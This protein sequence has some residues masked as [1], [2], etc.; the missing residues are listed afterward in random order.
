MK[1][2]T[3]SLI[4]LS[5][6]IILATAT[7]A[8][9]TLDDA[10]L[11]WTLDD[12][13]ISGSTI[14]DISGNGNNGSLNGATT[15]ADGHILEDVDLDGTNDWLNL[16][17][18]ARNALGG[19]NDWT[20]NFWMDGDTIYSGGE[21][22]AILE[23]WI[24]YS[25]VYIITTSSNELYGRV[26]DGAEWS[27]TTT[28][29]LTTNTE[30]MITFYREDDDICIAI[31][32]GTPVC[33]AMT[34]NANLRSATSLYMGRWNDPEGH[35]NGEYDEISIYTRALSSAERTAAFALTTNPY[36]APPSSNET[37]Y[38][39]TVTNTWTGAALNNATITINGE[40]S[41][42]NI[43]G[44]TIYTNITSNASNLYNINISSPN[45]FSQSFNNHNISDNNTLDLYE[46]I[47]NFTAYQL[48]SGNALNTVTF[49]VD[50]QTNGTFYLSTGQHNVTANKAGY[51]EK[52]TTITI[53]SLQNGTVN[54]T[55][56]YNQILNISLTAGFGAGITNITGNLSQ[57]T[58]SYNIN[59]SENL[60]PILRDLNYT[61]F[62]NPEGYNTHTA[63]ISTG[64]NSLYNL[65]ITL[66]A[67]NSVLVTFRDSLTETI[68]VNVSLDYF[69]GLD[70]GT[71][72]TTNGSIYLTLLNPVAY[73][74]RINASGYNYNLY[75]TTIT[76]DSYSTITI[77][78]NPIGN[79]S[80]ITV[81]IVDGGAAPVENAQ[82]KALKYYVT[83]NTYRI[84]A[85]G[86]TNPD[87]ETQLNLLTGSEFYKFVVVV[88]NQTVKT[89][90][91]FIITG[92]TIIIQV[93][94]GEDILTSFRTI[95]GMD[96]SLVFNKGTN[97]FRYD[98]T[99]NN[100]VNREVCLNTYRTGTLLDILIN[101]TCV[102]G[103]SATILH[104][105]TNTSGLSYYSVATTTID[106]ESFVLARES[107]NYPRF[108]IGNAGLLAQIFLT[109]I[110][111]L[112]GFLAIELL[113]ILAPLSIIIG[114]L[115]GLHALQLTVTVPLLI[116]GI[117]IMFML[118]RNA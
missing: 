68:I 4:F 20:L 57:D 24:D 23:G 83:D 114:G 101:T 103:T 40:G 31:D 51:Y 46:S 54:I 107:Y 13:N 84:V 100:N 1:F 14:I 58:Y 55:G 113:L 67:Y 80:L 11:Y 116:I 94:I 7:S 106:S 22:E 108:S 42:T 15:G 29:T 43:T 39:F 72:T 35:Y 82:V 88:D 37:N 25:A 50:G 109:L 70:S 85:S 17:T 28:D 117:I 5:L 66:Y 97:S 74:F 104:G 65:S 21:Y 110:V 3:V 76:D 32:A 95:Q 6:L 44:N 79:T 112:S 12:D 27:V 9:A 8:L 60:I 10:L 105:V 53:S 73:T 69:S 118:R 34:T 92:T 86:I 71:N 52:N 26:H 64:D 18:S 115:A 91:P 78:L 30:H 38:T 47:I 45:Y 48:I 96:N 36:V 62:V 102:T 59:F 99:D 98:F 56:L 16:P 111:S 89:T 19:Y 87:G 81:E 49:G 75:F 41:F 93:L 61:V 33:T 2:K 90:S 77:Y 63:N